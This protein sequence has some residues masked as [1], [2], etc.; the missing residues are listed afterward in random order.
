MSQALR[1]DPTRFETY[2]AMLLIDRSELFGADIPNNAFVPLEA[3]GQTMR[4]SETI[5]ADISDRSNVDFYA[6]GQPTGGCKFNN[7]RKEEWWKRCT[8]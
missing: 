8:R 6:D 7:A 5:G 2:S 1:I 4:I 3:G